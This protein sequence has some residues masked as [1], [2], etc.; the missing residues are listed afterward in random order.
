MILEMVKQKTTKKT[1]TRQTRNHVRHL[2]PVCSNVAGRGT[3]LCLGCS[4]AR[5][6]HNECGDYSSTEVKTISDKGEEDSLR[7]RGCKKV[8]S[9]IWGPLYL[10]LLALSMMGVSACNREIKSLKIL[11]RNKYI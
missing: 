1:T 10:S 7:C 11:L 2:C 5:W 3:F 9:F 4:P 8:G 6:V